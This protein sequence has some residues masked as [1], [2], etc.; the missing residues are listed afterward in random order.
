MSERKLHPLHNIKTVM[1]AINSTG[2]YFNKKRGTGRTER[3]ALR[4]LAKAID[5]PHTWIEVEDHDGDND[6][7]NLGLLER[8]KGIA[9]RLG[10]AHFKFDIPNRRVAF[11]DPSEV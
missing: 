9:G 3:I 6:L 8:I 10:Y 1:Q 5:K 4:T 11:G 7:A 2:Y